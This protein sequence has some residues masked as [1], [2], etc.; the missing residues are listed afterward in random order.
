[1]AHGV[2]T[3]PRAGT[4]PAASSRPTAPFSRWGSALVL[5][6]GVLAAVANCAFLFRPVSASRLD[7][8]NSMISELEV[9]GQPLSWFFRGASLVSGLAAFAFA[10]GL[11]PRIP[12]GR[13][14]LAGCLALA[15]FG[16]AGAADALFPMDCA[17]SASVVCLRADQDQP[18]NWLY[19]AHTWFDVAGSVAVLV[20]LWF[21]G[22]HLMQHPEWRHAS[23]ITRAGF[24]CLAAVSVVLTVM[25]ARYLP[26]VG[27]VQR[28]EVLGVSCWLLVLTLAARRRMPA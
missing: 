20:S 6:S 7:P 17:P 23:A 4:A 26:G 14:G 11:R 16:L 21:L 24:A 2:A 22:R 18:L 13:S 27:V 1:M 9:P 3:G 8:V 28:F 5:V 10:L 12:A 15:L 19:Q 25:S